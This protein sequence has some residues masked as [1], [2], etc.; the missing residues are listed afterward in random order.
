MIIV[1]GGAGFIGSN[2]I[3]G[4]EAK[5]YKDIVV[6]DWLGK[7]DKWK[8]IAKRNLHAIVNPEDLEVFLQ[9]NK[10]K[11]SAIIHMGAISTTTEKD[12][13][14]IKESNIDLTWKLWCFCRDFKKQFIFASSA[15]TYAVK[16]S[17]ISPRDFAAS[18]SD[19]RKRS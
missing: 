15:A 8:N 13:D 5:G 6:V 12:V 10:E 17:T 7:E 3:A 16:R 1:T 19:L 18:S 4:L 2:I 14:L 11:I 9:D